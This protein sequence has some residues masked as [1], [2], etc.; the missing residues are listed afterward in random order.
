MKISNSGILYNE[1][2][3]DFIQIILTEKDLATIIDKEI[4]DSKYEFYFFFE[5][6]KCDCNLDI[7]STIAI[8]D[9]DFET[10][11]NLVLEIL[12]I[13]SDMEMEKEV[14]KYGS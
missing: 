9:L 7:I 13:C 6:K 14:N 8:V 5:H 3:P 11:A 4:D 1:I 10:S 12:K 2:I